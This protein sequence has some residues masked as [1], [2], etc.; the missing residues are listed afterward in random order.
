MGPED[1][2][3][4]LN[5][6]GV[7]QQMELP[8]PESENEAEARILHLLSGQPVHIDELGRDAKLGASEVNSTLRCWSCAAPSA[9]WAQCTTS[10][11]AES[12][13]MIAIIQPD[14]RL[15]RLLMASLTK[16]SVVSHRPLTIRPNI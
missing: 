15:R 14:S 4:E 12:S 3:D 8:R 9:T 1:I 11:P 7:P 5:V 6:R 10:W 2:L 13:S 16:G